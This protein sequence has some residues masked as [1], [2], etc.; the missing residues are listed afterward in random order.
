MGASVF[1]DRRWNRTNPEL[2]ARRLI[3]WT[4]DNASHLPSDYIPSLEAKYADNINLKRA[5]LYGEFCH[6]TGK[7]ACPKF[8]EK[9]HMINCP[10][11]KFTPL[12][13]SFD[14]NV[15]PLA[16]AV[17]QERWVSRQLG[18]RK[19][20]VVVAESSG[21]YGL[22]QDATEEFMRQFPQSEYGDQLIQIDGDS[23]GHRRDVM[24]QGTPFTLCREILKSHGY[25][26]VEI[27]AG[28]FNPR[29]ED[30][31]DAMNNA[32]ERGFLY[33]HKACHNCKRS[34]LTAQL[35]EGKKKL[36]KTSGETVTHWFDA[37][38]Y[39][40]FR[41]MQGSMTGEVKR[42]KAIPHG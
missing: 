13:F 10:A 9:R 5:H 27:V 20:G 7:A 35:I 16:Y 33:I 2:K 42:I 4:L 41:L 30:T 17:I 12:I 8:D 34:V 37:I 22:V 1:Q 14:F 39:P 6:L 19:I 25:S 38:K 26:R 11:D 15:E 36:L 40:V 31:I 3:A 29:E 21:E 32:F 23:Q 18:R 28:E 24:A